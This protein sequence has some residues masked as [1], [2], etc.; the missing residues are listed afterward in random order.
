MFPPDAKLADVLVGNLR[1]QPFTNT[2]TPFVQK[3]LGTL[4][5]HDQNAGEGVLSLSQFMT[6]GSSPM[7]ILALKQLQANLTNAVHTA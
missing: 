6:S 5:M 7:R 1:F 3:I 2:Y 4:E